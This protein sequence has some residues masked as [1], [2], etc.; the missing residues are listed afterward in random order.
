V[1]FSWLCFG[2]E[3]RR[4]QT[5]HTDQDNGILFE[6]KDAAD[7]AE[8]RGRNCCPS[9]ISINQ[10]LALCGFALCKGNIMASNPE[11]C[12]SR[13]EWSRRFAAF[14]REAS[15]EN[16]LG[17]S[18]YF[19]LRV[20]WGERARRRT[21]ASRSILDAGRRQQV[22]PAHDG[23]QRSAQSPAG[24]AFQGLSWWRAKSEKATLDLKTQGL[25]P[26]VDGA[27]LLALANGV[28]ANNT[29]ERLRQLVD[30]ESHRATGWGGVR[31]GLSL[32]PANPHAAAS[33]TEP[34]ESALLQSGRS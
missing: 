13:I 5:L 12:L 22:V 2:S 7:A 20:V 21:V 18:I 17:S 6:A 10:G 4:E 8:I 26:F 24:R 29:L 11:L 25:T 28:A 19:D 23:R 27:R 15:P 31:R 30:K 9:P 3:G 1:P 32:H 14:I 16:L 33:A 34:A